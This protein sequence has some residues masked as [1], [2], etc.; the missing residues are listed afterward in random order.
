[1]PNTG[2]N[3][4]HQPVLYQEVIRALQPFSPGR[5]IDAT[6]GAGGHAWGILEVSSPA[7]LLLGLDL[8]PVALKLASEH[9]SVYGERVVLR[10]SSY[11][12]L[13]D[14]M[15]T[16][17][18]PSVHGV[19]LDLGVSSMQLDQPEKGFSFREEGP[20]DMRFD[21]RQSLT[22]A[23][24]VNNLPADAL[25]EILW[26]YGEERQARVI[27]N[28]IIANR[29]LTT[30]IQLANVIQRATSG[31]KR[32][33]HP[34][35]LTFQALR[36]AVNGELQ[37]LE[38]ALP[39]AIKA[40]EPGGRLAVISFHSL[41]DRLVKQFMQREARDCIC[42][43]EQPVCTCQHQRSVKI[44]Q[45]LHRPVAA[46]IEENPRARSARLRVA[47]KINVA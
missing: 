30:T 27:A 14:Q 8:D 31:K 4:P 33:I 10:Q 5:Y 38:K 36:I 6:V 21:P 43:P 45:R 3:Y 25:A 32:S 37:A 11:V 29:P 19:L 34:A 2:V 9:L 1:M 28:A 26:K 24:L 44:I 7:G 39:D 42:P 22:A 47:E 17:G 18:W 13:L 41:E 23:D 20:L 35:T 12:F 46:E 15:H 40:L 16:L